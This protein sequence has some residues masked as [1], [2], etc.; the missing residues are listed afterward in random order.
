MIRS[1][2]CTAEDWGLLDATAADFIAPLC[3]CA[4]SVSNL[5]DSARNSAR[6]CEIVAASSLAQMFGVLKQKTVPKANKADRIFEAELD[7]SI[8][9]VIKTREG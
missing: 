2:G 8:P 3:C 4:S 5:A 9:Y 7:I 1:V 6:S